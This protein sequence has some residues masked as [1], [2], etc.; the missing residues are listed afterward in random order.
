MDTH[1][2]PQT[3]EHA[4]LVV[5]VLALLGAG[6]YFFVLPAAAPRSGRRTSSASNLNQIGK[7]LMMYSDVPS[8]NGS[9]PAS[10]DALFPMYVADQKVFLNPR[11]ESFRDKV[12]KQ[13]ATR[14]SV[15]IIDYAY[16]PGLDIN[17]A[18]DI[19][20]YEKVPIV[21]GRNVLV[22][23]GSVEYVEEPEFQKRLAEQ[24]ARLAA[25]TASPPT[26]ST[27]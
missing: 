22:I 14:N 9:L 7:A 3:F 6:V 19:V 11:D 20:A 16:E 27:P 13:Q 2:P 15:S 4:L 24:R 10:L 23:G 8:N 12:A 25:K 1:E 5:A 17:D 18:T 26:P 21:G